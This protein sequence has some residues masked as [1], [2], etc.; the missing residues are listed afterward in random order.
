M[1]CE[2]H[3]WALALAA[4]AALVERLEA[5]PEPL[6]AGQMV[7]ARR[8]AAEGEAVTEVEWGRE[9]AYAS[10]SHALACEPYSLALAAAGLMEVDVGAALEPLAL[11]H[12]ACACRRWA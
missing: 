5:A 8:E 10:F 12:V 4:A 9:G 2:A 11:A 3:P 6:A 1:A 7:A